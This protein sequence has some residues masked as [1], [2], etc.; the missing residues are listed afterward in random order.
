[1]TNP[2]KILHID[3][4]YK[5]T[6]FIKHPC[7]FISSCVSLQ[8]AIN[9]LKTQQFDL[10]ISEPHNKTILTPEKDMDVVIPEINGGLLLPP[11]RHYFP[12]VLAV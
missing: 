8:E 5:V 2:I 10:I 3:P 6:Y 4:N 12:S 9:L 11:I 7:S 1:M